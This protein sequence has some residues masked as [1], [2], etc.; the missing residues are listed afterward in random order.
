MSSSTA[1]EKRLVEEELSSSSLCSSVVACMHVHVCACNR[2]TPLSAEE[3][4][5]ASKFE[6]VSPPRKRAL[7]EE[8]TS[9]F[10]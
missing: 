7:E 6:E 1:R 4:K 5:A 8:C 2:N 9:A 10:L 3:W